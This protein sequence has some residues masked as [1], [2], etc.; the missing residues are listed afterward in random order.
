MM[1]VAIHWANGATLANTAGA[2]RSPQCCRPRLVMP[3][4]TKPGRASVR[5]STGPPLSNAQD[6]AAPRG[7][8]AQN[9]PSLGGGKPKATKAWA[10][11]GWSRTFALVSFSLSGMFRELFIAGSVRG[12]GVVARSWKRERAKQLGNL[13]VLSSP[14][15]TPGGDGQLGI[16]DFNRALPTLSSARAMGKAP[17]IGLLSLIRATSFC[18]LA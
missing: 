14:G 16:T 10:Q 15:C 13:T 8:V 9:S 11:A 3:T 2:E 6:S 12:L 7:A 1:V 18:R 5:S 17:G 4:C